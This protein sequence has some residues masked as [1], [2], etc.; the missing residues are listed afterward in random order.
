MRGILDMKRKAIFMFVISC[1]HTVLNVVLLDTSDSMRGTQNIV[2]APMAV[3]E[4]PQET[5]SRTI[6]WYESI[7]DQEIQKNTFIAF[8]YFLNVLL[9]FMFFLQDPNPHLPIPIIL[10]CSTSVG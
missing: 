7:E 3:A 6:E 10:I 1:I 2:Y 4:L 9:P 5:V 8:E